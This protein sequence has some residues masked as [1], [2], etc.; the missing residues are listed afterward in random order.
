MATE[1]LEIIV[2]GTNHPNAEAFSMADEMATQ[3]CTERNAI[4]H[5]PPTFERRG[6]IMLEDEEFPALFYKVT[7]RW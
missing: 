4:G 6:T 2:V 1:T 5:S 7:A 3:R